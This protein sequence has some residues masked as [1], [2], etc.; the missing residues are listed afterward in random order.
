MDDKE[1][2]VLKIYLEEYK[3]LSE[4]ISKRVDYQQRILRYYIAL[5]GIFVPIL[6][7]LYKK[8]FFIYFLLVAPLPYHF[9]AWSFYNHD[10]QIV[11][12]ARYI[13]LV[14]KRNIIKIV[15]NADILQW[16]LFLSKERA[17]RRDN[18]GNLIYVGEES[19]L[20]M[21][22]PIAFLIL[23]IVFI[24]KQFFVSFG[25]MSNFFLFVQIVLFLLD[26]ILIFI[27]ILLKIKVGK[28]Y[29]RILSNN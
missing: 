21:T 10:I 22:A 2:E 14:L 11:A 19:L 18:F 27:T 8:D 15:G 6:F 26:I 13:N 3:I 20:P 9:F 12:I 28:N 7:A 4:Q 23:S 17:F 29:A 16:E 5:T 25:E 1:K 24:Y